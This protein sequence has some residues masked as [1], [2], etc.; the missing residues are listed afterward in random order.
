[1]FPESDINGK[2]PIPWEADFTWG[3]S[4]LLNDKNIKGK[5]PNHNI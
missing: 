1:M 5:I 3:E 2:V 4:R